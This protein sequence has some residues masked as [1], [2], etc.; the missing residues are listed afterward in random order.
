MG[1]EDLPVPWK[2]VGMV[3][4][5]V[6]FVVSVERGEAPIG[7]LCAAHGIRRETGHKW[8][9]RWRE[10]GVS[11]LRDGS[12]VPHARPRA[13]AREIAAAL[14]AKQQERPHWGP[15]KLLAVLAAARPDVA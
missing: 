11:G 12:R 10:S 7:V 14:L 13:M 5:R 6:R 8:L 15:R 4:E 2:S 9:K 1:G 3:E